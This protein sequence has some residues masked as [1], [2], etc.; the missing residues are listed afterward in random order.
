MRTWRDRNLL[1]IF[2]PLKLLTGYRF[3]SIVLLI[4]FSFWA[5]FVPFGRHDMEAIL[6]KVVARIWYAWYFS[7]CSSDCR[8]D[9]FL[10]SLSPE[11]L[12]DHC[13]TIKLLVLKWN[14][15]L[16]IC[17]GSIT[18]LRTMISC[19]IGLS[20][21][22]NELWSLYP[23]WLGV[24]MHFLFCC[25]CYARLHPCAV[26]CRKKKCGHS[27]Q[28]SSWSIL[29]TVVHYWTPYLMIL[30]FPTFI[31]VEAKEEDQVNRCLHFCSQ[32]TS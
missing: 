24:F 21:M 25:R 2:L 4:L 11:G 22:P 13:T 32:D 29:L 8:T 3:A 18:G 14:Q 17:L 26:N 28:V 19:Y 7:I 27:N 20:C 30:L 31:S 10:P 23:F 5:T 15:F 12:H 6:C 9:Q 16:Y 1:N